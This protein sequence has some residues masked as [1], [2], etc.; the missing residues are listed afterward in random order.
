MKGNFVL[1]SGWTLVPGSNS[2]G[3]LT[4]I[5]SLQLNAG[6]TNLLAIS[7]APLTNDSVAV[8][9]TLTCGG[10]LIVTNT[11]PAVLMA[12]DTFKLF[13]AVSY[14]GVFSAVILP[15]LTSGL[16]WNTNAL[17]SAGIIS[18]VAL[19]AP[20][21]AAVKANNGSLIFNSTGGV[22]DAT[23]YVL[24]STN[25]ALPVAQWKLA[26]SNQFDTNGTFSYTNAISPGTPQSYYLLQV[27]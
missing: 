19:P 25:P 8:G 14:S 21:I 11:G 18:V 7:H 9:G 26:V 3:A 16:A 27:P 24:T 5:N 10:V 13:N 20:G 23:Y 4:F 15:A 2:I 17:Y 1:G 12:G 22:A 6:N